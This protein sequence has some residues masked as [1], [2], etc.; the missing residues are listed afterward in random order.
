[1]AEIE[2]RYTIWKGL[3]W[4]PFKFKLIQSLKGGFPLSRYFTPVNG[5]EVLSNLPSYNLNCLRFLWLYNLF[6][7]CYF[8][9]P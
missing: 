1:M 9:I 5:R 6:L 8:L 4:D 2:I 7:V 3:A